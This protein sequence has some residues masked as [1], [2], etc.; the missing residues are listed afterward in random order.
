MKKSL[1]FTLIFSLILPMNCLALDLQRNAEIDIPGDTFDTDSV[2]L[3]MPGYDNNGNCNGFVYVLYRS[4]GDDYYFDN[5]RIGF[6]N[7][8]IYS[9]ANT[10][11]WKMDTMTVNKSENPGVKGDSDI[12]FTLYDNSNNPTKTFLYGGNG[13]EKHLDVAFFGFD[14]IGKLDGYIFPIITDSTDI[15]GIEPGCVL[16][17]FDLNGNLVW[18]K[19]SNIMMTDNYSKDRKIHFE[20]AGTNI[21]KYNNANNNSDVKLWSVDTGLY[22]DSC[23]VSYDKNG[24]MDGVIALYGGDYGLN[25]ALF[26]YDLDGNLIFKK[27]LSDVNFASQ[28]SLSKYVDDSYD[29]IMITTNINKYGYGIATISKYDFNGNFVWKDEYNPTEYGGVVTT[30][31]EF[32]DSN[33][34]FNGYLVLVRQNNCP[35]PAMRKVE[36]AKFSKSS[37]TIKKLDTKDA[38]C[39]NYKFFRYT[40]PSY[41]IIKDNNENGNITVSNDNAYPG[42]VVSVSVTTKEGYTLKRIVVMDESGKEI[43]VSKDG[44]FI[45]PEG[46]VTVTAIYNK[47]SN[48]ETVSAC[49]VVLG[50]ILLISI[51]TLIVQKKKEIV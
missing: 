25:P 20:T 29:G 31:T 34:K 45:M 33:D 38:A 12:L 27:E 15:D 17:K 5:Y 50:I 14:D 36:N 4:D 35:A 19:N 8:I 10:R 42:E 47:I 2:F 28:L 3:Y 43:E 21:I 30:P 26:K 23:V 40:Y 37:P 51:G 11:D 49:Y 1:I 39:F 48:P 9:S 16:V 7:K 41:E 32:I 24:V 6:D 22:L 13:T 44:T 46:K 18:Q